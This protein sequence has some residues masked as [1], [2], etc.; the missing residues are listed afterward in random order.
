MRVKN[1]NRMHV[2]YFNTLSV[3]FDNARIFLTRER[4]WYEVRDVL[5]PILDAV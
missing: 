2:V 1:L 4:Y 3:K 5:V